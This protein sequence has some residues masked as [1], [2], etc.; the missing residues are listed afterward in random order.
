[1]ASSFSCPRSSPDRIPPPEFLPY[2]VPLPPTFAP[3]G[4]PQ[5]NSPKTPDPRHLSPVSPHIPR[6]SPPP[7]K[8]RWPPHV[9]AE[10]SSRNPAARFP[11]RPFR[12]DA[13]Q[14]LSDR[15]SP[16][17]PSSPSAVIPPDTTDPSRSALPRAHTSYRNSKTP[18]H[19]A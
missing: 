13:T 8:S 2:P 16:A 9:L 6:D 4:R 12:A 14:Y 10:S 7:H 19:P 17:R 18:N 15:K 1:M 3:K 5:R 11:P